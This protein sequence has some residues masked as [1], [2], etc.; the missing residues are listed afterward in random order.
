MRILIVGLNYAPEPTGNAPYTTALARG[1]AERGHRVTVLTGY[2]H[3]PEWKIPEEYTGRS[4]TEDIDG[5]TVHRL[6][7]M[8]PRHGGTGPA[9][10]LME[11][12]FGLRA[13]LHRWPRTDVVLTVSPALFSSGM[14][15]LRARFFKAGRTAIWVQDLYSKGA[16]EL[17]GSVRKSR[18]ILRELET[19]MLRQADSVAVIHPRFA[20]H[21]TGTMGVAPQR[22]VVHRNWSHL[23]P[24]VQGTD[25]EHIRQRYGWGPD[26]FMVLHAGNMG[27]KQ[28]LE[29]V[30]DAARLAQETHA[31]IHFVLL[32][33]G[34]RR[35]ALQEAARG[36]THLQFLPPQEDQDFQDILHS[37]DLLLV[38]EQPGLREMA[39]P[40][41]LTSY[42]RTGLPVLAAVEEDGTTAQELHAAQ[43]GV[44][45][46]PGQPKLLV[47]AALELSRDP[48]RCRELGS[49]GATHAAT[50]LAQ[51]AAL[52][53]NEKWLEAIVN[54]TPLPGAVQFGAIT[55]TPRS[56]AT[57]GGT[58]EALQ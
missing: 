16:E 2:P 34:A 55:S 12:H 28:G 20:Q 30:V 53:R 8:V 26:D 32:G 13:V 44:M 19:R 25:R 43:A 14:V 15:M 37:A 5:V 11:L 35:E 56:S 54:H 22:V 17:Q 4:R 39:V 46:A 49:N 10:L 41:K 24:F 38:N 36:L 31:P 58:R 7:H 29:N 21:V 52:S 6:R 33:S 1:L 50:H 45:V 18:A 42:F 47:D 48:D 40:S 27:A 51:E 23:P 3:Y 9:R 57:R